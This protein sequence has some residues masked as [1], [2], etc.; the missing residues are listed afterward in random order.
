MKPYF[1]LLIQRLHENCVAPVE[2][3]MWYNSTTFDIVGDLLFGE[4]YECLEN[5]KLHVSYF[6]SMHII[7][8]P[9][10]KL[11]TF[12]F[13]YIKVLLVLGLL[14]R[15]EPLDKVLLWIVPKKGR[16]S[17]NEFRQFHLAKVN[18]RLEK[19]FTRLDL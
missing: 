2:M 1:D 5:S 3:A 4:S 8:N 9:F 19:D 17:G 12:I 7:T 16:E 14:K 15:I 13:D 10:Q 11:I 6:L 18:Q